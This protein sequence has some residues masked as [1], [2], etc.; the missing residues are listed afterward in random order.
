[1]IAVADHECVAV[2]FVVIAPLKPG[3]SE[4]GLRMEVLKPGRRHG[5]FRTVAFMADVHSWIKGTRCASCWAAAK[6]TA[7]RPCRAGGALVRWCVAQ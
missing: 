1:M 3:R 7:P 6:I 4:H 5:R 2:A